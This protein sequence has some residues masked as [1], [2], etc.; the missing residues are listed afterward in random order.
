MMQQEWHLD[1]GNTSN[2]SRGRSQAAG[3]P[4]CNPPR[5]AGFG[6][7]EEKTEAGGSEIGGPKKTSNEEDGGRR[8]LLQIVS[9][10]QGHAGGAGL[11]G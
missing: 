6:N 4:K 9:F 10:D 1:S 8:A 5:R 3:V 2:G 11:T 7:E